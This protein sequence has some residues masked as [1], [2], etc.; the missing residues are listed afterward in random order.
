MRFLTRLLRA[1]AGSGS[2]SKV[3]ATVGENEPLTR[4][5]FLKDH[6]HPKKRMV[7][8]RGFLPD[9]RGET[10]ICRTLG[11]SENEIWNIGK[12]IRRDPVLARA[13]FLA[14]TVF[15]LK[16]RVDAAPEKDYKQHAVIVGWPA[17]KHARKML[18]VEMSQAATL[19]LPANA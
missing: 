12:R 18:A 4:Y 11:L 2:K 6:V 8:P 16:L 19:Q 5:L 13:D 9:L 1:F 15:R 10:S 3:P 17:E 7:L 14:A